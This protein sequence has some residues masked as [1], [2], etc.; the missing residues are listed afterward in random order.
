MATVPKPQPAS[1]A[2][3]LVG[4]GIR[5]CEDPRLITGS[6]TYVEDI[7]IAGMQYACVV[8][9]PHA[10]AKIRSVNTSAARALPGVMAVFTGADTKQAGAVPCAAS[11]PGLRVPH[12]HILAVDRVYFV[13]HPVAVV[14]ANDRYIARDAADLV[15]VDYQTLP[16]VADPEKALAAGAPAV[17]PEWP[18]NVAF[19]F[20]Q[21]G[22][23]VDKAFREADVVVKERIVSQR[24]I[25]TAMETR[26]V[27]AEWRGA[28]KS[29]TLYSST[30]IPH[31]MRSAVAGMLGLEENRLRVVAPEVGGGFGSKLNVYAEE[32]LMGFV[33]MH[34][35][36]PVKWIETRRENFT[37]TIHGRGHVD[38]YEIAAKRD[39]TIL[40]LK[41][42]L[43]QDLGAYHQ[44]L[45]PAIPTL[46]V[47]MMP[48]VYKCQNVRADIVGV[49]TNCMPTDAYRGAGRPEA[50]HGIERIVDKLAQELKMDPAEIRLKN[51]VTEFPYQ[52]ATGLTY[53]S[54]NYALP[55][56]K[57]LEMVEYG[58]LREEQK[59]GRAQ[60]RLLGIGI[61]TYGEICAMGPSP[62]MPA[63]GWES[64]TVKIEPSGKVTVLT[65]AS[66]HGQGQETT[67]AQI[68]ADEMGVAL[69]DVLVVHG[70]TAVVQY[71]IGTFGSRGTAV[72]GTA[73]YLALQDLKA[74]VKKFGAMLLGSEDV[75][76][77]GGVCADNKTEKTTTL[78]E[79]AAAAYGAKQL[80]PNTEPGLVATRYWEPPNFTFPFGAHVVVTEV[81][82]ETG[83]IKILR[84]VAVD[85]CGKMI[86]PLL[87][88]GQIH[89]G[90]AQG[91][92]QALWEQA[93]YDDN[94][95][96]ITGELTDYAIPKASMMPLIENSHTETPSP[97]NPLGVKGVG[98]A[99]TIGCSPAV[100][101]SVV[102]ALSPFGVRHIDMP[103]TP[104]KIWRLMEGG[105][106]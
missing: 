28:E 1:Q 6:A 24:L 70:D 82:R 26:G 15:E 4:K 72:G 83:Q 8:R 76:F 66:P 22:G 102:D 46:S 75:T 55:L 34:T 51:F 98:E 13:G 39:S 69:S 81:D 78:A 94:G 103:L 74:K 23:D 60:G 88:A 68:A 80:P 64:A 10:A 40:G 43:I 50:T 38:Y 90:V 67:F 49:F 48:G 25:P 92:G 86:N 89:G 20:H 63:G 47:L 41:L 33:A 62:A 19:T 84:Y 87:V 59:R 97:V 53:D 14:V 3:P 2:E 85:D 17:H 30:Q 35:G 27:V 73:V 106:A 71:G 56:K 105:K 32:A 42:K 29:L 31:L 93:V 9:S 61:S 65:G 45:T 58:K 16:A 7:Q 21:E 12:H 100:V 57:A 11:L 96:L 54:G 101:N 52:T 44:L 37:C 104:E 18:D 36:K 77:S 79:I 5:R 95:Q 99:G 91:L